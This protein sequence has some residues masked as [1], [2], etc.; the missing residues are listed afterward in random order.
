MRPLKYDPPSSSFYL[1]N[2]Y[3]SNTVGWQDMISHGREKL[4]LR[5]IIHSCYASLSVDVSVCRAEMLL[6]G[7]KMGVYSHQGKAIELVAL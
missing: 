6:L 4:F 2:S 5:I 7:G 3:G 1:L